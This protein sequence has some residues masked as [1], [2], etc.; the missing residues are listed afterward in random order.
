MDCDAIPELHQMEQYSAQLL[1]LAAEYTHRAEE[2]EHD[3]KQSKV[4]A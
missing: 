4:S 2:L 3:Y 1:Q